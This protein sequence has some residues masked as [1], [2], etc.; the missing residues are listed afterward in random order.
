MTKLQIKNKQIEERI[1]ILSI[2]YAK[3]MKELYSEY[4][5]I[6]KKIGKVNEIQSII[7]KF[8]KGFMEFIENGK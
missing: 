2:D 1:N 8:E 6:T 4:S 7:N 3:D 5:C